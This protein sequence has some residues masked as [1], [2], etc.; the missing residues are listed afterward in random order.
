MIREKSHSWLLT[1]RLADWVW[2][3]MYLDNALNCCSAG[4]FSLE[5][6][7]EFQSHRC[8]FLLISVLWK[9]IICL[10]CEEIWALS[11]GNAVNGTLYP[12]ED[13]STFF[14]LSIPQHQNTLSFFFYI[15]Q[16]T[17]MIHPYLIPLLRTYLTASS[18]LCTRFWTE[19]SI[20][21]PD[22]FSRRVKNGNIWLV[23]SWL[24]TWIK[25]TNV[26]KNKLKTCKTKLEN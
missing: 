3:T 14:K 9:K 6:I 20:S 19:P 4:K 1:L 7:K 2:S 23:K 25:S 10:H 24:W 13:V 22:L 16:P 18:A 26:S 17:I 15:P 5:K 12:F 21:C 8:H 11:L